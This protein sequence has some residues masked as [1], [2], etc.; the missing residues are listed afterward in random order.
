MSEQAVTAGADA[1]GAKTSLTLGIVGCIVGWLTGIPG[2]IL[3]AIGLARSGQ[4]R[5]AIA[6][7][8]GTKGKALAISGMIVSIVS[9]VQG[10]IIAIYE[11]VLIIGVFVA[12]QN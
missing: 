4:A 8:P 7:N 2:I 12:I 6:N 10:I 5:R 1:P 9:L 3:G 11:T